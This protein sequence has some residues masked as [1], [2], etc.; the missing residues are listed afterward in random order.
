VT[1]QVLVL[2]IACLVGPYLACWRFGALAATETVCMLLACGHFDPQGTE[3]DTM[4]LLYLCVCWT[5][6]L[7]QW[8]WLQV[9]AHRGGPHRVAGAAPEAQGDGILLWERPARPARSAT[10]ATSAKCTRPAT[11]MSEEHC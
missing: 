7:M 3:V 1:L 11:S 9:E 10:L 8:S 5:H 2:G 6:E 4:M